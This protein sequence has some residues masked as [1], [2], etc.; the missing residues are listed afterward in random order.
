MKKLI[1][2]AIV[3]AISLNSCEIPT[4]NEINKILST[5]GD[6]YEK[7]EIRGRTYRL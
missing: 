1:T 6:K 3:A 5:T 7:V 4:N 2:A